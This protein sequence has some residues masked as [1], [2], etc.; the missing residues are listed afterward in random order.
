[1]GSKPVKSVKA[2][3]L[4]LMVFKAPKMQRKQCRDYFLQGF[5]VTNQN[6]TIFS[7]ASPSH[8]PLSLRYFNSLKHTS[9]FH[10][11]SLVNWIWSPVLLLKTEDQV[12]SFQL[13]L[14]SFLHSATEQVYDSA[15]PECLVLLF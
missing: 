11:F 5:K 12:P 8:P 3:Y 6:Q 13:W 2:S 15:F 10:T 7:N 1:M 14:P 4:K 9:F